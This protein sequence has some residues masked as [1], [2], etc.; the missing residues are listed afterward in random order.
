MLNLVAESSL[1]HLKA[2]HIHLELFEIAD[3]VGL[4]L[5]VGWERLL[6]TALP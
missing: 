3:T 2:R 4:L 6:C 1:L 5:S